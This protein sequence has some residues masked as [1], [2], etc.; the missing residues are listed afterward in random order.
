MSKLKLKKK[1]KKK[2]IRTPIKDILRARRLLS[3]PSLPVP[4]SSQFM[5]QYLQQKEKNESVQSQIDSVKR[6]FEEEKARTK[7]L[8]DQKHQLEEEL[9]EARRSERHEG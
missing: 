5:P 6:P 2:L 8:T 1:T 4:Q 7:A 3:V 9:R